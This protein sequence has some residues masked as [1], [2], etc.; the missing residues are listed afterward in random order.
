MRTLYITLLISLIGLQ[1]ISA[2]EKAKAFG[3]KFKGFVNY[4]M[5]YDSRQVVAARDGNVLLYPSQ[6]N[7]DPNGQDLNA[8]SQFNAF[9]IT[10]RLQGVI[11]GPDA[12]GAKTS[13]M[14]S[15][16][17]FGTANDKIGLFRLRQAFVKL[18]WE[19]SD[20]LIGK[21][22]HPL[23]VTEVF[24]KV[25]SF[26]AGIPI[27][28]L[29]RAPQ[30]AYTLKGKQLSM[31]LALSA[32]QDFAALGPNG[33]SP[34]YLMNT[35]LP[36]LNTRLVYKTDRL[37]MGAA[38]GFWKLKPRLETATGYQTKET[39]NG[40]LLNSFAKLSLKNTTIRGGYLYGSNMSQFF[41]FGGY[42]V[43]EVEEPTQT[44]HY[45]PTT[46]SSLWADLDFKKGAVSLGVFGGYTQNHGADQEMV[47]SVYAMG[48]NIDNYLRVAPRI[49]YTSGKVRVGLEA[50]YHVAAYGTT[51]ANYQVVDANN[52]DALR[53]L[54][55]VV[56]S[57]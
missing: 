4:E 43:S 7:E 18:S 44:E 49:A 15:G 9:A 29:S 55:S 16:D 3:I 19:K 8:V 31:T 48:A 30:L 42:G 17:F 11:S 41:M 51:D 57:F 47:G 22:W 33:R 45:S 24:P 25:L 12:L 50:I 2:Q 37:L 20:L 46:A 13:G 34:S 40:W 5:I 6:V 27:Y 14:I 53:V 54:T 38:A 35:G 52:V 21:S 10:T 39:V 28:P 23:F 1:C 32:Q 36:E 26:G 56:Y